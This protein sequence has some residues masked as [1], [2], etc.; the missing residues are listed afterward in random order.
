MYIRHLGKKSRVLADV[1]GVLK[2]VYPMVE[3]YIDD[4]WGNRDNWDVDEKKW[5]KIIEKAE[6]LAQEPQFSGLVFDGEKPEEGAVVY[7]LIGDNVSWRD[8]DYDKGYDNRYYNRYRDIRKVIG[9]LHHDGRNWKVIPFSPIQE[10]IRMKEWFRVNSVNEKPKDK[11]EETW[12]TEEGTAIE[13][14]SHQMGEVLRE[15]LKQF[16]DKIV[17]YAVYCSKSNLPIYLSL[18]FENEEQENK[19]DEIWNDKFD[20]NGEFIGNKVV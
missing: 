4:S 7:A 1:S 16:A 11:F 13:V 6:K 10:K 15:L 14:T 20:E 17:Y 12:H 5:N 9:R 2:F 3:K 8:D 18:L 19:F